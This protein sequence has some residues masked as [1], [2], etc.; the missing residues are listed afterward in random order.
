MAK[1]EIDVWKIDDPEM[2]P[3]VREKVLQKMWDINVSFPEWWDS[4]VDSLEESLQ[5]IAVTIL[6]DKNKH[7]IYFS[8]DRE[9][10]AYAPNA[11]V[12]DDKKFLR[13]AIKS[14]VKLTKDEIRNALTNGVSI[15]NSTSRFP[16]NLVSLGWDEH[17]GL[18][19]FLNEFFTTFLH[20]VNKEYEYQTSE[21]AVV[22]SLVANEYEFD[23]DG[24]IV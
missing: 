7:K 6:P 22:E 12:D 24:C 9:W 16:R 17:E 18:T 8:S 3:E 21:E 2:P 15:S 5:E 20:S 10:Y 13:A 19:K 1:K 23:V 4:C 14:G 11:R